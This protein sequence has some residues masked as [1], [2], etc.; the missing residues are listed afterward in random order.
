M[1]GG[2]FLL[3]FPDGYPWLTL[4]AIL[5]YEARTFLTV[6]PFG[7]IPR[8]RLTE[9]FYY[10]TASGAICQERAGKE[11][12]DVKASLHFNLKVL[13]ENND[14]GEQRKNR[15]AEQNEDWPIPLTVIE[16]QRDQRG[17]NGNKNEN[18][19]GEHIVLLRFQFGKK[20]NDAI[21]K[22]RKANNGNDKNSEMVVYKQKVDHRN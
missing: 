21:C 2:L 19:Q 5:S 13:T 10:Y 9:L 18:E 14:Q 6:I 7:N 12:F 17:D 1:R 15:E 3:H 8:D 11:L 22:S 16:V 20:E 4:S